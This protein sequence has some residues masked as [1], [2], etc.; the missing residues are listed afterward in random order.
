MGNQSSNSDCGYVRRQSRDSGLR[1]G[2]AKDQLIFIIICSVALAVAAVTMVRF[3]TGGSRVPSSQWQC[4]DCGKEFTVKK[5]TAQPV[6][7]PK[8]GGEAARLGYR[9]C[10]A[11]GE[12]VLV[13]RV[14]VSGQAP[15]GGPAGGPPGLGMMSPMEIQYRVRQE[16]GTYVWT[17]WMFAGSPQAQQVD[18]SLICP[19]CGERL[20]PL[21][22]RAVR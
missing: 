19:K 16:D 13:L 15:G 1:P 20:S 22:R 21:R 11:C 2:V 9:T 7:C 4:L 10:P 5:I 6:K 17:P 3:F 12:K 8:C 18:S 14:R